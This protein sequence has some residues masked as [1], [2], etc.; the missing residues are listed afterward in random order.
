LFC[1]GGVDNDDD[2]DGDYMTHFY[3]FQEIYYTFVC[4]LTLKLKFSCKKLGD[5]SKKKFTKLQ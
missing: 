1:G 4:A 2:G 5:G 3:L